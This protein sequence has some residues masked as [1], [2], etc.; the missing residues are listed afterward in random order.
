MAPA[1]EIVRDHVPMHRERVINAER[2]LR[3]NAKA[4]NQDR[5][6][7]LGAMEISAV[8]A[9]RRNVMVTNQDHVL[10]L[11]AM[12]TSV[13][14]AL[15][16]GAMS[17]ETVHA[18]NHSAMVLVSKAAAMVISRRM[19]AVLMEIARKVDLVPVISVMRI[20]VPRRDVMAST[21]MRTCIV[22]MNIAARD[23]ASSRLVETDA[24]IRMARRR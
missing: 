22:A 21:G 6:L 11:G 9:L 3:R 10:K 2:A 24:V 12:V 1:M 13:V 23:H 19:S 5:V 16:C 18:L 17:T 15:M 4:T 7:K 8:L 14:Q 20:D